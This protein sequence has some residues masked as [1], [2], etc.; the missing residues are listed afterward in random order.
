MFVYGCDTCIKSN[1]CKYKEHV[2]DLVKDVDS[3]YNGSYYPLKFR[4]ECEEYKCKLPNYRGDTV[5]DNCIVKN[6]PIKE[7]DLKTILKR[8]V[9]EVKR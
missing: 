7:R 9:T 2:L 6:K 8:D 5:I 1:V 3:N 4:A